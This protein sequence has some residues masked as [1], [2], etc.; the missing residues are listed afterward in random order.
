MVSYITHNAI[1]D[2][3]DSWIEPFALSLSQQ[4]EMQWHFSDLFL[5]YFSILFDLI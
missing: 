2:K 1:A 5:H 4:R 3:G